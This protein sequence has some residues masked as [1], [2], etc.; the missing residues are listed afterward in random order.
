MAGAAGVGSVMGAE[1][2]PGPL[3]GIAGSLASWVYGKIVASR[4]I[5]F[6]AGRGVVEFDRPT[7]SVGNL[8]VGGTGKTPFVQHLLGVLLRMGHAPCVAMRGYRAA[9]GESDESAMYRRAFPQVPVVAQP[10][11][12]DGLIKLFATPEGARTDCIVLDDGFQHRRIAREVDFVLIDATRT[13]FEDALLPK[14]WLRE[15]VQNLAR[16]RDGGVVVTHAERASE[17]E[18]KLLAGHVRLRTGFPPVA[19]TKH[20]WARLLVSKGGVEKQEP[21]EWLRAK[22]VLAVCAIGNPGPFLAQVAGGAEREPAASVVLRD[23]DPYKPGTLERIL[24]EAKR[25]EAQAIVTTEKDWTK[26][27]RVRPE[28]WPCPVARPRLALEFTQGED[29]VAGLLQ[30]AFRLHKEKYPPA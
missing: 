22:R 3:P 8:S 24:G 10:N 2:A 21:V 5:K 14:G 17:A 18:L 11:R 1:P 16:I 20:A 15:P 4:N 30:R 25:V 9:D 23:H 19:V 13:P 26:L 28:L 6:D 12:A 7:I 29:D 27:W